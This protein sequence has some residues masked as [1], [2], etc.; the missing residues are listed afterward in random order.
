MMKM[1]VAL[2]SIVLISGCQALDPLSGA[3]D[4]HSRWW[5][6]DF[7][8]PSYMEGYVEN[9]TVEDVEGRIIDNR[10]WGVI[11]TDAPDDGTES[12]RGW[13]GVTSNVRPVTGA[14][15]PRRIYVRWQSVVEPQTYRGWVEIPEEARK[16]M[17]TSTGRRCPQTKRS[18]YVASL[19]LGLAPG[20]AVQV[21]A[22]DSC[23][24]A[25]KVA[26]AQAEIEPL[27]P[28]QGKNEG[29]YAYTISD[30][31]KRYIERFGIPYG[32]W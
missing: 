32:S 19:I 1:L 17:R 30:E 21:W 31:S 24:K 5:S 15:L 13:Y 16:V 28:S 4:N 11:G 20:G 3:H 12:A 25:I 14:A 8:G 10:S 7:Q 22:R 29:R 18:R 2:V 27:G 26:R 9:S 23:G 6:I